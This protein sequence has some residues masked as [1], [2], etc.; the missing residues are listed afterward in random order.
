[1]S[2]MNLPLRIC[3]A[4]SAALVPDAMAVTKGIEDALT[5]LEGAARVSL[6]RKL[7]C[8]RVR[9]EIRDELATKADIAKLRGYRYSLR[10]TGQVPLMFG[11]CFSDYF[12]NQE[13]S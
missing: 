8:A 13:H 1:M 10:A 6:L 4:L 9:I 11:S 2:T 12:L 5:H 3:N 7:E